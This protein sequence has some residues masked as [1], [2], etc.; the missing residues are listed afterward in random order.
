MIKK[1]KQSLDFLTTTINLLGSIFQEKKQTE[2]APSMKS[3]HI[4]ILCSTSLLTHA[5]TQSEQNIPFRNE[6]NE[7]HDYLWERHNEQVRAAHARLNSAQS[8]DKSRILDNPIL[9]P[10]HE[11]LDPE[12]RSLILNMAPDSVKNLQQF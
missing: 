12:L 10:K 7:E 6:P 3:L 1:L 9:K 4:F 2:K 8:Q 5:T 11:K